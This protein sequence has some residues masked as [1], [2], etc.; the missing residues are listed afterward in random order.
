MIRFIRDFGGVSPVFW[1]DYMDLFR[2]G[3]SILAPVPLP[4]IRSVQRGMNLA[5]GRKSLGKKI[6]NISLYEGDNISLAGRNIFQHNEEQEDDTIKLDPRL[7]CRIA[8]K[9]KRHP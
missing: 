1:A 2:A 8:V 4:S 5:F 9:V 6:Y 7:D 3:G